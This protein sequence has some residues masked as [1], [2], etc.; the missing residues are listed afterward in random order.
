MKRVPPVV[1]AVVGVAD[2]RDHALVLARVV[3]V[4]ARAC[5]RRAGL[6]CESKG[7]EDLARS[8]P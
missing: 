7:R 3:H 6:Q 2:V 4:P 1:G 5:E 8:N